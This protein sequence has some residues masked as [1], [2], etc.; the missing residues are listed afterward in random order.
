VIGEIKEGDRIV[1]DGKNNE[2]TFK[3]FTK[4]KLVKIK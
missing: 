1:I 4:K 2:I 3:E